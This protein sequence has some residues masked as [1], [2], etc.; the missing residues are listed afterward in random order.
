MRPGEIELIIGTEEDKSGEQC[1]A[2]NF[3]EKKYHPQRMKV[4]GKSLTL[5]FK[6][7][8]SPERVRG[9]GFVTITPEIAIYHAEKVKK[10][11]QHT[12]AYVMGVIGQKSTWDVISQIWG[13]GNAPFELN[14]LVGRVDMT[15]KFIDMG[16]NR[17][18]WSHPEAGLHPAWQVEMADLLVRLARIGK[19]ESDDS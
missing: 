9:V 16:I 1:N 12:S 10:L 7:P 2:V 13:S 19:E 6:D 15:L 14:H 5:I 8:A 4:V 3:A 18:Q 17:I 11:H